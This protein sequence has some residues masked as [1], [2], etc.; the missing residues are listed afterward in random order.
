MKK[1]KNFYIVPD[2]VSENSLS[3]DSL[4]LD[5]PKSNI[6]LDIEKWTK[7]FKKN[8]SETF[9]SEINSLG[10]RSDE[11]KTKHNDKHILFLGCSYTWGTGMYLEEV[12][13]KMLYEK[14]KKESGASGFFNLG[15]PGDSIYS[16]VTNAFKYFKNFGNP[17]ILFFNIQ[18]IKRF[19]AYNKEDDFFYR[20]TVSDSQVLELM[21]YQYYYML[22]QYCA[23]NKILLIG[24]TWCLGYE[25][26]PL[27]NLKS[28]SYPKIKNVSDFV[29]KYKNENSNQEES[30]VARD[31]SHMGKAYHKYWSEYAY[32]QY[33]KTLNGIIEI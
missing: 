31:G 18:D 25:I 8:H 5:I 28:F 26:H 1:L 32:A 23:A 27:D 12:W 6:P 21:A 33:K 2:S 19:Y 14:I 24:F 10:F 29:L 13:S 3:F 9:I 20:S 7:L 15:V 22:E 4:F 16:S 17:D 11:F 30:L